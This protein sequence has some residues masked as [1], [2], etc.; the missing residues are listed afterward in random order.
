MCVCTY[1]SCCAVSFST[2]KLSF[3]NLHLPHTH[4]DHPKPHT[5][6]TSWEEPSFSPSS[7]KRAPC[8][9]RYKRAARNFNHQSVQHWLAELFRSRPCRQ[10]PL[11][12]PVHNQSPEAEV[13]SN[14]CHLQSPSTHQPPTTSH[15]HHS[16][17]PP[18]PLTPTVLPSQPSSTKGTPCWRP[19]KATEARG[20]PRGSSCERDARDLRLHHRRK[21][22]SLPSAPSH[23][24]S[25]EAE[26]VSNLRHFQS[27]KGTKTWRKWPSS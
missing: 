17:I 16:T 18:P 15:S 5:P 6:S 11:S 23:N 3:S 12:A 4:A 19:P 24:E 22:Q 21:N 13:V 20:A 8:T 10:S 9:R 14:L 1:C 2:H 27:T 25:H 7:V 26:V